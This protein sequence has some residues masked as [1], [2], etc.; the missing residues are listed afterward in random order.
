MKKNQ[1][2]LLK[3]LY[4]QGIAY[5]FLPFKF[6]KNSQRVE[7]CRS[8]KLINRILI[9]FFLITFIKIFTD[10]A[11]EFVKTYED[12]REAIACCSY[13][14][15]AAF[16]TISYSLV[17]LNSDKIIQVVNEQFE[18]FTEALTTKADT[19]ISR[20]LIFDCFVWQPVALIMDMIY[21]ADI[22]EEFTLET[23][24][25]LIVFLIDYPA[26]LIAG[27]VCVALS[28]Q[29]IILEDISSKV[30]DE[31]FYKVFS[32]LLKLCEILNPYVAICVFFH[33]LLILMNSFG[34]CTFTITSII[35]NQE[36]RYDQIGIYVV[37]LVTEV[38]HL[39]LIIKSCRKMQ[40]KVRKFVFS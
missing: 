21:F 40:S 6:N 39:W 2:I 16:S 33:Y 34:C 17:S 5:G 31:T 28:V 22:I 26:R 9:T 11:I 32:T 29:S 30:I 8:L 1:K 10:T 18:Y 23:I 38:F 3:L 36:F 25:A 7:H 4:I 35:S 19:I 13:I 14:I 24:F 15:Y 37:S 20:V 12:V 27:F